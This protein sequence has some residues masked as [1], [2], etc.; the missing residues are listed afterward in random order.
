MVPNP[1]TPNMAI[2][3]VIPHRSDVTLTIYDVSGHRVRS[4]LAGVT[5]SLGTH[6]VRWDGRSDVGTTVGPGVY[7]IRLDAGIGVQTAKLSLRR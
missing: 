3:Y 4:L 7:F 2:R 6:R 1:L 5:Q